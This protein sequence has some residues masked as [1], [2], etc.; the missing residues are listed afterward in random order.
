MFPDSP[1]F[2]AYVERA[3][4]GRT[5]VWRII[6]GAFLTAA[7]ALAFPI[8]LALPQILGSQD[9]DS[10]GRTP[11]SLALALFSFVGI[12]VGVGLAVKLLHR[13]P[14]SGVLG[15]NGRIAGGDLVRAFVATLAASALGEAVTYLVDPTI[16]RTSIAVGEW[17]V[18]LVPLTLALFVQVSAEEVAFRGYLLQS[19]AAR[20][21]SPI[22]WALIPGLAF[23][24]LHFDPAALPWMNASIL[25]NIA[26]FAAVATLLVVATGNLGAAMGAHLG[27][28]FWGLFVVS[29]A[30]WLDGMALLRGRSLQ[31]PGWSLA[32]SIW[33]TLIG[34]ASLMLA[35]FLL[36]TPGSPLRVRGSG[37]SAATRC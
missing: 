2:R 8:A 15:P 18:W 16:G 17:L 5:A 28:N 24:L 33:L 31:A 11:P 4:E 29:H 27:L 7:V 23:T 22:L 12:S 37:P 36:V 1:A 9:A 30:G 6:A 34:G 32:D 21:R 26:G 13:R 19:L 10:F 3:R 14:L 35:L 25:I 20:F